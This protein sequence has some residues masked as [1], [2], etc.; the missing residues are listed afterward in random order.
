MRIS[1]C[2]PDGSDFLGTAVYE[3]KR[4]WARAH[5]S[6]I[7]SAEADGV[8]TFFNG[9][10]VLDVTAMGS[11]NGRAL[12]LVITNTGLQDLRPAITI[13][14]FR[15]APKAKRLLLDGDLNDDN[16]WDTRNRVVIQESEIRTDTD[17]TLTISPHSITAV[18]MNQV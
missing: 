4:L 10:P 16:R 11:E 6:R 8:P 14:G 5:L 1:G 13:E 15:P 12:S 18:L 3:M 7:V 17:F 9:V 2:Q